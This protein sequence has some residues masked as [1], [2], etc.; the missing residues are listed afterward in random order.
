MVY[1]WGLG[2]ICN[3]DGG[4]IDAAGPPVWATSLTDGSHGPA[5]SKTH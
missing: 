1:G 2:L 3:L 5:D 4:L